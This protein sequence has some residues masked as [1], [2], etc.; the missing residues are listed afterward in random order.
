M[1]M[2]ILGAGAIGGYFGAHLAAAGA[3]VTFL[4]RPRRAEQI[5]RD[6]LVVHSRGAEIRQK[7]KTV[8]AGGIDG[9]YDLILVACKAYD[10]DDAIAAILPAVGPDTVILPILNGMAHFAVLDAQFG[11]R[12]VMGGV[13]L[14]STM[15]DGEG[16]IRHFGPMDTIVF[17]YRDGSTTPLMAEL[18][19]LFAK[20]PVT[21]RASTEIE[22][23]L[24]DKWAMLA[25]GGAL[26]C[27]MRGHV[28]EIMATQD[29]RAIAEAVAEE[30]RAVCAS[31][32]HDPRPAAF[33]RTRAM[34]TDAGSTFATSMKRDIDNG[35]PKLEAD[36]IV[37]DLLRRGRAAGL[38]LPWLTAAYCHL[39]V[40]AVQHAK[41]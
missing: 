10:L 17:G 15:L 35:M 9:T 24:W 13:C 3:D 39:Q 27:L 14:I 23:D 6:G 32:G 31:A 5:A 18:S 30:C 7:V 36:H 33:Q 8:Q 1:K 40:Y 34:M 37:G 29:G 4:V 11:A 25:A 26:T 20:T 16:H 38:A 19:A 12:Q 41:H 2:L 28:G 21:A 22:Q